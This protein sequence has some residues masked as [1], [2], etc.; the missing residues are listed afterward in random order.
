MNTKTIAK[1]VKAIVSKNSAIPA[2]SQ[3]QFTGTNLIATD[4]ETWISIPYATPFKFCAEHDNI[5]NM[6][7]T[8]TDGYDV[9]QDESSIVFQ[10][11]KAKIKMMAQEY[12]SY[13]V[14][15][16]YK[17]DVA[18]V[19]LLDSD[20]KLLTTANDFIGSD[21]LRPSFKLI[22]LR[23]GK[24]YATDAHSAMFHPIESD[25]QDDVFISKKVRTLLQLWN[26]DWDVYAGSKYTSFTNADGV[27]ITTRTSD[28]RYPD[29]DNVVPKEN[30]VELKVIVKEFT[31]II[32]TGSKFASKATNRMAVVCNEG[33][34]TLSF[35]DEELG[36][37]YE[38]ELELQSVNNDIT[39]GFNS[40][41]LDR[42][43]KHCGNKAIIEMSTPNRA[44]VING[45]FLLMPV[46]LTNEN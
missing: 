25:I 44:A 18:I 22:C 37:S 28:E 43:F 23:K 3:I 46:M 39:I 42:V 13:P 29:I 30:P 24:M 19:K 31:D 4:L 21:E 10:Y 45:T 33:K 15:E 14:L 8:L 41:F 12:E 2:C 1:A 16:E 27:V 9:T 6:W 26:G 17:K 40:R 38:A 32:K 11:G 5:I 35:S 34:T 7:E 20:V 36:Q